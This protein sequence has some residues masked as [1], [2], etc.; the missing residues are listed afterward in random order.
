MNTTHKTFE[1]SSVSEQACIAYKVDKMTFIVQP[2]YN[3]NSRKTIHE[4]LLNLMVAEIDKT[5]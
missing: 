1:I 4:L 5:A 2:A 3:K